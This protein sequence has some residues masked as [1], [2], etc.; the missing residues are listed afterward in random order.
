[1]SRSLQF[2][3]E[4]NRLML[5]VLFFPI[6][7]AKSLKFGPDRSSGIHAKTVIIEGSPFLQL[8]LSKFKHAYN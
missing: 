1:M 8:D 2:G 4:E 6:Y 3:S 7:V 5:P